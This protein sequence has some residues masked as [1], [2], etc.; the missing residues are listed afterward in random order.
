MSDPV[1]QVEHLTKVYQLG[2]INHGML[3]HDLESWWA[4]LRGK[5]GSHAGA[6]DDSHDDAAKF[7]ALD[8]VSFEVRCGDTV[9]IIGR[10][11]AGKSTL[12]KILSRI[13]D[14]TSGIFPA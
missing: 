5:V 14:P 12:L 9:G 10:N 13:T 1:I 7:L 3:R 8:A 6:G 11:G 2:A 4:R